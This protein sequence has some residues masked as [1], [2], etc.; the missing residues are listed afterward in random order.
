MARL[1][2]YV[3]EVTARKVRG[4]AET[5]GI[6]TSRYLAEPVRRDVESGWPKGYFEQVVGGW[7]GGELVRPE[8]PAVEGR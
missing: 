2:C 8:Q 4:R 3:P 5:A 7:Q 1:Y 6:S